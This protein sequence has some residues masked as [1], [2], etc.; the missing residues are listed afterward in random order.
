MSDLSFNEE[1]E[2]NISDN[3]NICSAIPQLFQFQSEQKKKRVIM[4]AMRKKERYSL[5]SCCR[6]EVF[7]KNVFLRNLAKFTEKDLRQSLFYN[8]AAGLG[9]QLY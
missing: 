2:E 7:C 3:E 1:I 6:P 8:K 9:L 4:R 5:L